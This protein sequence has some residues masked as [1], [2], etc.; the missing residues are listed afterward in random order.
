M[1]VK[2]GGECDLMKK[3]ALKRERGRD[4]HRSSPGES[5]APLK[6]EPTSPFRSKSAST[7]SDGGVKGI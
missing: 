1:C 2:E 4:R 5:R 7:N 3:E 6:G